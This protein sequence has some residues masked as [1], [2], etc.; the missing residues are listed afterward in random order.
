MPFGLS[1]DPGG[2]RS[3][4]EEPGG[5]RKSQEEPGG[6][7][8]PREPGG[9]RRELGGARRSQEEPGGSQE[10]ARRSQ[11][12][13][14]GAR[15]SQEEPGRARRSQEPRDSQGFPCS[16]LSPP[17]P[18]WLLGSSLLGLHSNSRCEGCYCTWSI[19]VHKN[20]WE[21]C[22]STSAKTRMDN[23]DQCVNYQPQSAN[24]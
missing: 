8:E 24:S 10:G 5:A 2:A 9:A 21:S 15:K 22:N 23:G 11:E 12:E 1:R 17:R 16:P 18:K 14:G 13:P 7:Q 3:S 4:Q 20:H 6:S 19:G